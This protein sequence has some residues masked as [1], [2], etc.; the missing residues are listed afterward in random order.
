MIKTKL[1]KPVLVPIKVGKK[2]NEQYSQFFEILYTSEKNK[3]S[4]HWQE[5]S[6]NKGNLQMYSTYYITNTAASACFYHHDV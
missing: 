1:N 5:R 4:L 3:L 6:K 2:Q